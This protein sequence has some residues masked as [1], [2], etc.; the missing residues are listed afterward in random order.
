MLSLVVVVVFVVVA[1]TTADTTGTLSCDGGVVVADAAGTQS[2]DG[3]VVVVVLSSEPSVTM[4]MVSSI[5]PRTLI[6]LIS[7]TRLMTLNSL[8]A[9]ITA[10]SRVLSWLISFTLDFAEQLIS[11]EFNAATDL[12]LVALTV[13][14]LGNSSYLFGFTARLLRLYAG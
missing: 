9:A 13:F 1:G 6:V 14:F 5:S 10:A 3:G 11:V 7:S 2:R 12:G 8:T 4:L